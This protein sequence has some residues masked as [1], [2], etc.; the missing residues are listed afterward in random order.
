MKRALATVAVTVIGGLMVGCDAPQEEES[1]EAPEVEEVDETAVDQ[2]VSAPWDEAEGEADELA[3]R[4]VKAHG[5]EAFDELSALSFDFV[6][7]AEGEEAFRA[8]HVWDLEANEDRIVWAVDEAEVEV[9]LD[10]DGQEAL[11]AMRDGEALEGEQRQEMEEAA[12]QRWVNDTYWLLVPLKLFD[13][14]VYRDHLGTHEVDGQS[15]EVLELSFEQVGLTPGDRYE[16]RVE[17]DSGEI[18]SWVMDLEGSDETTE[19]M[20]GGYED[21]GPLRLSLERDWPEADRQIRLEN[22]TVDRD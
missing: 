7:I 19:V 9:L 11:E 12:Y 20:W 17:P 1:L 8:S 4:V 15:F 22:V 5:V 21:V 13:D 3:A 16:L 2:D 6:V 18:A 14:G 10:V